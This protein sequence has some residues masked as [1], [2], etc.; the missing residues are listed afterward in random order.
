MKKLF[1]K[2]RGQGLVE[3]AIILALVAIVVIVAV[4]LLGP[5]IGDIFSNVVNNLTRDP[6]QGGGG[7]SPPECYGTFL[8]PVMVGLMGLMAGISRIFP[9]RLEPKGAV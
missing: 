1:R 5:G 3:Y 7:S 8:T 9:K 6:D 2:L 4:R